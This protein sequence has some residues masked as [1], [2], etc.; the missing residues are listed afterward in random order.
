MIPPWLPD[1]F[2]HPPPFPLSTPVADIEK[3]PLYLAE[4]L[5]KCAMLFSVECATFISLDT[6]SLLTSMQCFPKSICITSVCK[7]FNLGH[8]V[9][10]SQAFPKKQQRK[11]ARFSTLL[12]H[13]RLQYLLAVKQ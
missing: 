11:R 5:L 6:G 1:N 13:T 9:S 10:M 2:S 4:F 8:S 3:I 12:S 7:G